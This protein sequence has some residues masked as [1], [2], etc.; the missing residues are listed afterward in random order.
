MDL[1]DLAL[2]VSALIFHLSVV[3]VYLAEKKRR[4]E[5]VR[6]FGTLTLL[7]GIPLAA[8]CWHY[9]FSGEPS[10]K[11]AAF[12]FIFLY[13]LAE[14][15]LDFVFKLDFHSKL[16]PHIL[17]ILMFY[18]AIIALIRMSFAVNTIWGYA[19]SVSFWI[20]LVA[21][22]YNLTG[23]KKRKQAAP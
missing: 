9:L 21:L 8:V 4:M 6:A 10:W 18:A 2:V 13:L 11:L 7:T 1:Y 22:I 14:L 16:M 19:I 20:L 3:G 17:Y 12:G 15:L 5:L 23:Q